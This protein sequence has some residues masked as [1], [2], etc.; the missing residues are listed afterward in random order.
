MTGCWSC[1]SPAR[2][3]NGSPVHDTVTSQA[4]QAPTPRWKTLDTVLSFAGVWVNETYFEKIA[5]TRSPRLSQGIDKS[6]IIIPDSTLEATN[7]VGGFHD[8]GATMVV[9]KDD[10]RYQFYNSELNLPLDT[11]E[12]VSA[13]RL[14]IGKDYFRLLEHPDRD[15][16]DWGILEEMLFSGKYQDEGGREVVFSADGS[17]RGLTGVSF[18]EPVI[19]YSDREDRQVDRI[20]MGSNM[21]ALGDYGFLFRGDTLQIYTIKCL[22]YNT[23]GCDSAAL[24]KMRWQLRRM[25]G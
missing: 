25:G 17:V 16:P 19:D 4:E 18:F 14:R 23:E 11:I 24:G 2:P 15:K 13:T 20:R 8:G 6:C 5:R 9:V 7:M 1:S 21:K 12:P 3:A 10:K 22:R